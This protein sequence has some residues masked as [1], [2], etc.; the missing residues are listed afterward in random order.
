[1]NVIFLLYRMTQKISKNSNNVLYFLYFFLNLM[2]RM[3]DQ[4]MICM[5]CK[6]NFIFYVYK[7]LQAILLMPLYLSAFYNV[8]C[9]VDLSRFNSICTFRSQL[10]S[11]SLILQSS[12]C[13]VIV[14]YSW[15]LH[16]SGTGVT[17]KGKNIKEMQIAQCQCMN[18]SLLKFSTADLKG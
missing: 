2:G 12:S 10:S 16:M 5:I 18:V 6:Q 9:S 1:M 14:I 13:K 17:Q 3:K 15:F 11:A 7:D 4:Q 8:K